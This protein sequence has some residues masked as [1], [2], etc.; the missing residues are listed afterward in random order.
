MGREHFS[1]RYD[2]LQFVF[3][4]FKKFHSVLFSLIKK[5]KNGIGNET[6]NETWTH[7][8]SSE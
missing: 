3:G 4:H 8:D 7:S 2:H 5:L 6:K 1:S